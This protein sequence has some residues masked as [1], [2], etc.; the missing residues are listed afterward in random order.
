MGRAMPLWDKGLE[1][2]IL[3]TRDDY[4]RGDTLPMLQRYQ[5]STII[6]P[7]KEDE[8][9]ATL[10]AWT[11]EAVTTAAR[12][13]HGADG[14]ARDH[15]A[16]VELT[17]SE[18][19]NQGIGARLTYGAT[20][21]ERPAMPGDQWDDRRGRRGLRGC[22]WRRAGIGQ[23][24]HA[25]YVAWADAGGAPPGLDAKIRAFALRMWAGGVHKRCYDDTGEIGIH[26]IF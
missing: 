9:S 16:G 2:L 22:A 10:D 8:P 15:R 13:I 4:V 7:D 26:P 14:H 17:F 11:A 23:C 18:R 24:R 1:L 5:V 21:F 25:R 19:L 6:Q 20:S 12:V 3:P